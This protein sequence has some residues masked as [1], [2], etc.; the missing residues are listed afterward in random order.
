MRG[1]DAQNTMKIYEEMFQRAEILEYLIVLNILSYQEVL[2]NLL[3]ISRMGIIPAHEYYRKKAIEKS[4]A[5]IEQI[6]AKKVRG[7]N[8]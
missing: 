6:I 5:S 1:L 8:G 7:N 4:G 2:E 3:S